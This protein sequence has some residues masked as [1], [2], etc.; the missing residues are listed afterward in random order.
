MGQAQIHST[1]VIEDGAVIADGVEIGPYAVIGPQVVIAEGVRIA[2]HCH[3]E[4]RTT[5][6]RGTQLFPGAVVGTIPQDKKFHEGDEVYLEI[7]ERNI[8]REYVMINP[9]TIDGGARTVIGN[10]NLFMAY[11]HV[12]HDCRIGN[13]CVFANVAT[14]AGHVVVEDNAIVGGLSGVHQFA[15]IGRLAMIGG[16]S[17]INQDVP[18]FALCAG[19][20]TKIHSVNIVG[21]RRAG[22]SAEAIRTLKQAFKYL[23]HTGRSKANALDQIERELT[24][25]PELTHLLDFVRAHSERGLMPGVDIGD[26]DEGK[27]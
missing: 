2:S 16:C 18:P 14:I 25:C 15:R 13:N 17:R 26:R 6:G 23:F 24:P 9:G 7:G 5:I 1:A 22:V 10:G 3:I 20:D 19:V 8:I 4:G 21:L 11:S 27:D 12:A